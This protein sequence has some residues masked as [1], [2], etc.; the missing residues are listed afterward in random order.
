MTDDPNTP[1]DSFVCDRAERDLLAATI[2]R[3]IDHELSAFA[4]DDALQRFH[5]CP[6]PTVRFVARTMWYHY[7]DCRDHLAMLSKPEWDYFQRL[8]L[9]LSSNHQV[10]SNTVRRWSWSQIPAITSLAGFAWCAI[11][12][13]W[14][15]QFMVLSIPFGVISIAISLCTRPS[16]RVNP[17]DQVLTPFSSFGELFEARRAVPGFSKKQCPRGM[18]PRRIRSRVAEFAMRLQLYAVWLILSPIPLLFQAFPTTETQTRV[19]MA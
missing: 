10:E 8:L 1:A 13:G 9:L 6:D 7:D 14:G 15:P 5:A 2:R 19:R 11:H 17:Y 16:R 3:Y 12:F 4:F 18:P